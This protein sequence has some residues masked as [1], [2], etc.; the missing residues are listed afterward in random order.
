MTP[1]DRSSNPILSFADRLRDSRAEQP[2]ERK[3]LESWVVFRI[4]TR[5]LALPVSHVLEILRLAELTGVPNAPAPVA[6]IM[7]LRGHVLP[8]V[9]THALLGLPSALATDRSR[10]LICLIDNRSIGL[11]VDAVA[12][13]E[14]LQMELVQAVSEGESL[15]HTSR[16]SFPNGDQEPILL[17]EPAKLFAG[18][19]TA[20]N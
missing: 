16:G 2:E 18:K 19:T 8:V 17:L 9:D 4:S 6:G 3:T 1:S 10:V 11:I 13:L 5:S 7:N 20:L 14:R 15:A 12:G